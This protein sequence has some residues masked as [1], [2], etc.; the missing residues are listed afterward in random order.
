MLFIHNYIFPRVAS[1][2]YFNFLRMR[3]RFVP[4][5]IRSYVSVHVTPECFH[6]SAP[7]G[8]Q[9]DELVPNFGLIYGLIFRVVSI[10][11]MCVIGGLFSDCIY[12][13]FGYLSASNG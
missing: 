1:V 2:E 13:D 6:S 8:H 11:Y 4:I 5:Y 3:V 12:S 9:I 7:I 10:F